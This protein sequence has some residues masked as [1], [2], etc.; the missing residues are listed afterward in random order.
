MATS[1]EEAPDAPAL[2]TEH[3]RMWSN[4]MTTDFQSVS[5]GSIPVFRFCKPNQ[6]VAS[7]TF[8]VVFIAALR[9][10]MPRRIIPFRRRFDSYGSDLAFHIKDRARSVIMVDDIMEKVPLQCDSL[11]GYVSSRKSTY[12]NLL[13][14]TTASGSIS[15]SAAV[16][17]DH[18]DLLEW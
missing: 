1:Q 10:W 12:G 13:S 3:M 2:V 16:R 17:L 8:R 6:S 9:L 11:L 18:I 14:Y 7:T 4:G 15:A 5:A